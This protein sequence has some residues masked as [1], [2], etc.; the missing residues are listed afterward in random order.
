MAQSKQGRTRWDCDCRAISLDKRNNISASRPGY[1]AILD[2]WDG[3]LQGGLRP[4]PGLKK[5]K[6]LGYGS[7]TTY[8]SPGT[9]RTDPGSGTDY[10]T[11]TASTKV[12]AMGAGSNSGTLTAGMLIEITGNSGGTGN[13]NTGIYYV[14]GVSS[15]DLTL[16]RGINDDATDATLVDWTRVVFAQASAVQELYDLRHFS[17]QIKGTVPVHG[18][19]CRGKVTAG[20]STRYQTWVEW[21]DTLAA[22]WKVTILEQSTSSTAYGQMLSTTKLDV[23]AWGRLLYVF[24]EGWEPILVTATAATAAVTMT[25]TYDTG[26]GSQPTFKRQ[27][28]SQHLCNYSESYLHEFSSSTG[29]LGGTTYAA[30][31]LNRCLP[32][33][34]GTGT[35]GTGTGSA[36]F[37]GRWFTTSFVP[38]ALVSGGKT[39]IADQ[40]AYWD[41]LA[42]N[43]T[44]TAVG[45][46]RGNYGFAYQLYDATTG[47]KSALSQIVTQPFER[48]GT[49]THSWFVWD[50][51][52]DPTKWTH[53][54]LYRSVNSD[55]AGG[56]M[57][58]S[59]LFAEANIRLSDYKPDESGKS[60]IYN[61][62]ASAPTA[63]TDGT[64]PN[65]QVRSLFWNILE[66]KELVFQT[67]YNNDAYFDVDM[68]SAGAAGVYENTLICSRS[69]DGLTGLN[70]VG[71]IRYSAL[72]ERSLELFPPD[73]RYVPKV[74]TDSP[75]QYLQLGDRMFG[76]GPNRQYMIYKSGSYM[77]IREMHEGFGTSNPR[78]A[79]VVGNLVYAV[80]SKG[81]VSVD[82][83]GALEGVRA[84]DYIFLEEWK[85]DLGTVQIAFDAKVA[86]LFIVRPPRTGSY[87]DQGEMACLWQTTS[88]VT[89]VQL[90]RMTKVTQGAEPGSTDDSSRALFANKTGVLYR[91]DDARA[92]TASPTILDTGSSAVDLN[93]KVTIAVSPTYSSPGLTFKVTRNDG[94]APTLASDMVGSPLAFT[95]GTLDGQAYEI[96]AI[97]NGASTI[98]IATG[99]DLTASLA[100]GNGVA[101]S[102]VLCRAVAPPVGL[103]AEDGT[104]FGPQNLFRRRVVNSIGAHMVTTATT[105]TAPNAK[106]RGVV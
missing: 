54:I 104:S 76:L 15:N 80:T 84:L 89:Q 55:S 77:T 81:L 5:I 72:T 97:N 44:N 45:L 36:D 53:A 39:V 78:A 19:V 86:C 29:A 68:P 83:S 27:G 87:T 43:V 103:Q 14:S 58:N 82:V 101:I 4:F 85:N 17:I 7:D 98:T 3:R 69:R 99:S 33:N 100:T 46:K 59:L 61:T 30:Y 57:V 48:F 12:L 56:T 37:T 96:T 102:P 22:A 16:V 90:S 13:V 106:F 51:V 95:S 21:Y 10:A 105:N 28:D 6:Q 66:D 92:K 49:D 18:F 60:T 74:G 93:L 32:I 11:W 52:Y 24:R 63:W 2:G 67:M 64:L 9:I 70:G 91:M 47:R 20:G 41:E 34:L 73:S 26:P 31:Y 8:P 88:M 35:A 23:V 25:V 71:E 1:A 62:N 38:P 94:T 42:Y 40:F 79:C 75:W 50:L 65:G